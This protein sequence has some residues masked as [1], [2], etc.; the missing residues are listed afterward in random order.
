MSG[1]RLR[2]TRLLPGNRVLIGCFSDNFL[3]NLN[4]SVYRQSPNFQMESLKSDYEKTRFIVEHHVLEHTGNELLELIKDA[5][6]MEEKRRSKQTQVSLLL[7]RRSID[8]SGAQ[9]K[10][11]HF[12]YKNFL[13][14]SK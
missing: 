6:L 12:H 10:E 4:E 8:L 5:E 1:A 11:G 14:A 2:E 3:H 7:D 9:E 13:R